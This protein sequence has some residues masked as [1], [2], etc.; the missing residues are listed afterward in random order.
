MKSENNSPSND[1]QITNQNNNP[2]YNHN[3]TKNISKIPSN[4]LEEQNI[5]EKKEGDEQNDFINFN[6]S[7]FLPNYLCKNIEEGEE[8]YDN[9][10]N[11]NIINNNILNLNQNNNE[12]DLKKINN[13]ELS[14]KNNFPTFQNIFSN[15][16]VNK[17]I[18]QELSDN[19][20]NIEGNNNGINYFFYTYK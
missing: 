4:D 6:I 13:L 16:N 2:L 14:E 7:F 11:D 9:K 19:V 15:N 10:N 5:I 18:I 1:F 20:S 3:Q 8:N 12:N 17:E